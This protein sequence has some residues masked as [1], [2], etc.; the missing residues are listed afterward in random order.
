M[1]GNDAREA[2]PVEKRRYPFWRLM[3]ANIYDLGLLIRDSRLT[4]IAFGL[5]VLAGTLYEQSGINHNHQT[6]P[7][8]QAVYNT[9]QLF[10]FQTNEQFPH[11]ALG[12]ILFF[13]IPLLGL[14]LIV[15]SVLNFGRRVLDKGTRREAWQ[16]ALASTYHNHVIVCGLGR[17][18]LR[19]VTRLIE[20]GYPPVVVEQNWNTRFVSRAS[21]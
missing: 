17:I 5:V 4:L 8:P 3:R 2:T 19:V 13:L 11:D 21:A 10:I 6:L 18:G 12:Q 14:G 7:W 20:A 1:A 16:V 9:L 15:Q